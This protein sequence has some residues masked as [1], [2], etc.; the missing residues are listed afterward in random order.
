MNHHFARHQT[1]Q[2]WH[3]DA[4]V[5]GRPPGWAPAEKAHFYFQNEFGRPEILEVWTAPI[6]NGKIPI[7]A[8]TYDVKSGAVKIRVLSLNA[9]IGEGWPSEVQALAKPAVAP[10]PKVPEPEAA[11]VACPVCELKVPPI[12]WQKALV[13]PAHNL[14]NGNDCEA[15]YKPL[16][17][18]PAGAMSG[19]EKL[20]EVVPQ[21][22]GEAIQLYPFLEKIPGHEWDNR[23]TTENAAWLIRE[24]SPHAFPVDPAPTASER[25]R[26]KR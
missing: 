25:R 7:G 12:E 4:Q 1:W 21:T 5:P 14:E 20:M 8:W 24:L 18:R 10:A 6:E 3:R 22:Y 16:T 11:P 13:F 15:S 26:R 23:T 2:L 9:E 17:W 19:L